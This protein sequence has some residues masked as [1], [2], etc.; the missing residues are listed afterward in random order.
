MVYRSLP[1]NHLSTWAPFK[2]DALGLVTLLGQEQV[3]AKLGRLVREGYL[4]FMPL[5]GAFVIAGDLF[6]DRQAGFNIYNI[7]SGITTPELTGWLTRWLKAQDFDKNKMDVQWIVEEKTRSYAKMNWIAFII[8]F[9]FQAGFLVLTILIGD[10]YGI[11]NS[12]SMTASVLV[13]LYVLKANRDAIDLAVKDATDKAIEKHNKDPTE[14]PTR[15]ATI[16]CILDDA[17]AIIMKT[18][19]HLIKSCFVVTP[20]PTH[21]GRYWL[22]RAA[23]WI[24][25]LVHIISIGQSVLV[26]QMVTVVLLVIPTVALVALP[27]EW[28]KRYLGCNEQFIAKSLTALKTPTKAKKPPLAPDG[29]RRIHLYAMCQLT[30]KE[31]ESMLHWSTMPHS[32]NVKWW[33]EYKREKQDY[34]LLYPT[35]RREDLDN[36]S[37]EQSNENLLQPVATNSQLVPPPTP[38]VATPRNKPPNIP[39]S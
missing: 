13:R 29:P 25:F 10:W 4:D 38:A 16:L 22:A 33:D 39:G 9:F 2:I 14:D 32:S 3:N 24:F 17:T 11:A 18:P 12:L 7:T 23:G 37:P 30:R 5:L 20:K 8:A 1:L 35:A 6:R 28:R 36:L 26:S 34:L 19:E 31:E 15:E 27:E 21:P